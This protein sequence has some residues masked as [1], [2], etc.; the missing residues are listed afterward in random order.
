MPGPILS[1][2]HVTA[3][4]DDA[5]QDLD[6]YVGLLGLRLVKRTVNFD[7]HNVYHFYYGDERGTPSTIWTTFPYKGWGVPVGVK[8]AGQVTLTSFSVPTGSLAFWRGRLRS[9]GVTVTELAP[10]FGEASLV[11]EDPSGLV[12]ELV[13]NDRDPRTPWLAVDVD[14]GQAIRGIHSVSLTVH[15]A[16]PTLEFLT[17][18]LGWSVVAEAPGRT[19]VGIGGSGPGSLMDVVEAPAAPPA[20]NGLGTV[21]HVAMAIGTDEQQLE[22][23]ERLL[24]LGVGVT[25][26]RDRQYFRSIYFREPGGVLYEVATISPGFTVDEDLS[27]LGQALKLP[28]WEEPNRPA[29]LAGLPPIRHD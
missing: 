7:N 16:G 26:V 4:A 3:T 25:E 21:H 24:G 14:P 20:R 28:P 22:L 13:G 12:I 15:A 10:R 18:V 5:Q 19:R 29:I 1:L 8:G 11:F 9:R 17:T 23:R 27:R 2:H 6:C